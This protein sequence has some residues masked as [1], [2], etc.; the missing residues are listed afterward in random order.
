M[1]NQP[2]PS[3]D[4]EVLDRCEAV[5]EYQ[6]QDRDIL[7]NCLTHA[8]IASHRLASNER[9]EFL[10]DAIL[11]SVVCEMLYLQFPDYAEG[12]LTRIKS[13]VVSRNSCAR[14]SEQ[15]GFQD[16]LLLGRGLSI[17]D[18]VPMSVMAAVLESVIAGV[19]LD[20]GWEQA[21]GLVQRLMSRQI[22]LAAESHHGRN[23]KSLLQQMTQKDLGATPGYTLLDEQGP[24]HSKSF[25]VAA[26]IAGETYPAAWGATKKEAEQRAAHNALCKLEDKEIPFESD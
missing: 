14:V 10:G 22:E 24:D 8:S 21:R 25:K 16:F 13:I 20:G 7:L 6:F 3:H 2:E 12:E 4:D 19:Y 9:L 23:Y 26:V 18:T 5:L 17:H 1:S 15:L 11:G